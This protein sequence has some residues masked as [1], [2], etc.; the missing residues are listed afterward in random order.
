MAMPL[1]AEQLKRV[2]AL[3][4][5]LHELNKDDRAALISTLRTAEPEV[6]AEL[7]RWLAKDE[8][9][10]VLDGLTGHQVGRREP[11]DEPLLD[12]SGL[13]VGA[14]ELLR[15][16][17]RGG[18]G[19][20]YEARRTGADFD[21]RVAVKLLRRGLDSDDILR[22]FL[23]ERRILAQLDHPGIA[24]LIDGGVTDDGLPFL[25]MEFVD[26]RGLMDAALAGQWDLKTRLDLF[27]RVCDSVAYAHRRL[28]VHRD[29][30]PSNVLIAADGQPKLL[31]FGIAKLLDEDDLEAITR[32]GMRMLTPNY[33]APEQLLGEPVGTPTDVY[34]LGVILYE[35][36][37][38]VCPHKRQGT[39]S[40][41]LGRNPDEETLIKPSVAVLQGDGAEADLA[42]HRLARQLDGDL[43]AIVL[44]AM[45][46]EPERRYRGAGDFGDDIR[47]FLDGMPV[48]AEVDSR[49]YRLRKFVQRHRG[50]VTAAALAVLGLVGGLAI[51]LWQAD[52]ARANAAI[53]VAERDRA[54]SIKE[55]AL[56]LFREQDPFARA[57]SEPK[58]SLELI[59]LG[60]DL[61]RT[62]FANDPEQRGQ[63]LNDLGEIQNSLGDYAAAVPVLEEALALRTTAASPDDID[64]ATTRSNLA[65]SKIG[66][67]DTQGGLILLEE[68]A[69]TLSRLAGDDAPETL[70][71]R[72]RVAT[73]LTLLGRLD[74]AKQRIE[75]LL[76]V[77]ERV[78]GKQSSQ[79]MARRADLITLLE[80]TSKFDE[81]FAEASSLV[82]LIESVHGPDSMLLVRPLGLLGDVRRVQQKY[83][84][85][86]PYYVRAIELTRTNKSPAQTG[87]LLLRRGDLLR[88]MGKFDEADALILESMALLPPASPDRAQA[89]VLRAVLLRVTGRYRESADAFLDGHK[90]F[91]AALGKDSVFPWIAAVEYAVTE[92][93]AGNGAA[94]EPVLLDAL[95]HMRA[96]ARPD[97][98]ELMQALSALADWRTDQKRFTEAA[99]LHDEVVRICLAVYGPVHGNTRLGLMA[100][101]KNHIGIGTDETLAAA[102]KIIDGL[103]ASD[104]EAS[105]LSS[106]QKTKIAELQAVFARK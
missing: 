42:K 74:E 69:A 87:R 79:A 75:L 84:D 94:A 68:S 19:D 53:A 21:Q 89:L 47:R 41:R 93:M 17:G 9:A 73:A 8:E 92:R 104:V 51:A 80:Q 60:I 58:T 103:L 96:A 101:A 31:D 48:R 29:L 99:P 97:S 30:K 37:T 72:A 14:Y 11:R 10:G 16:V 57:K 3:F 76:P 63:L 27:L 55:F 62:R 78:H 61:A 50:G 95:A 34:A 6:A 71:T 77:T 25:V 98:S 46:R 2:S 86:D 82:S 40:D 12:R 45:R 20:V 23:R 38:G 28:I 64:Y 26:G 35:L 44:Y 18:M 67:G 49:T 36:L 4:D 90:T 32:T 33:A 56:S 43:D 105:P 39:E 24:R 66:L 70:K 85:A 83:P 100:Q 102:R 1:D 5:D 81:A 15:H 22:R 54:E 65:I 7:A 59:R 88:R 13:K 91:L 52:V 106:E